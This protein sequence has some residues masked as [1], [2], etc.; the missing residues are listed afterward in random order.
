MITRISQNQLP[1]LRWNPFAVLNIITASNDI[2]CAGITQ[3][4]LPC[5]WDLGEDAK[6]QARHLLI[7]MTQRSPREALNVLPQLAQLCLCQKFH[8]RQVARVVAQ[9]TALI[10]PYASSLE[11]EHTQQTNQPVGREVITGSMSSSTKVR[12]TGSSRPKLN[13]EEIIAELNAL[14]IRQE[15]LKLMLQNA[16]LDDEHKKSKDGSA[17]TSPSQD[18]TY[19][20]NPA[21]LSKSELESKDTKYG[22]APLSWAARHRSAR[23]LGF[24]RDKSQWENPRS[25][26]G[27]LRAVVQ[28]GR[29]TCWEAV[30]PALEAWRVLGPE[31]IRYVESSHKYDPAVR[32]GLAIYMIGRTEDTAAPKILISSTDLTVRKE[33]RKAIIES[34]IMDK[35][36]AIGLWDGENLLLL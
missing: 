28:N 24:R 33:V 6:L 8:Q 11:R 14:S 4:G 30:G 29:Y 16:R 22:Q 20:V 19:L 10:E 7:S 26:I 9:W 21:K 15:E 35:Y 27:E 17:Q 1:T 12:T 25:S 2:S 3:I 5:H 36:P 32:L 13:V 23:L 34:G 31:I 18:T